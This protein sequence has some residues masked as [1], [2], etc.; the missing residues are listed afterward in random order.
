MN[1]NC[2]SFGLQMLQQ[3]AWATGHSHKIN[4]KIAVKESE[5]A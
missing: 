3:F 5:V 2:N 1:T 4:G